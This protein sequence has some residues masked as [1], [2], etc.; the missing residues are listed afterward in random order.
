M[1]NR[2][3]FLHR[4]EGALLTTS[5]AL[6][7]PKLARAA[8]DEDIGE[9]TLNDPISF[10]GQIAFTAGGTDAG[11][12]FGY[13]NTKDVTYTARHPKDYRPKLHEQ[14]VVHVPYPENGRKY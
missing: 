3:E 10:S 7:A 11:M 2:C 12:M 14:T 6:A 13:F 9:L 4:A 8:D 5:M 1:I